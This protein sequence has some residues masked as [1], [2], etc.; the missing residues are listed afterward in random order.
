MIGQNTTQRKF[1]WKQWTVKSGGKQTSCQMSGQSRSTI[2]SHKIHISAQNM[3][4]FCPSQKHGRLFSTIHLLLF[5]P[6]QCKRRGESRPLHFQRHSR[7]TSCSFA[8]S[9]SSFDFSVSDSVLRWARV[10][11]SCTSCVAIS[12]IRGDLIYFLCAGS[13]RQR[14]GLKQ[15]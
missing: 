13:G 2:T 14:K 5:V 8:L 3:R 12:G 7:S 10:S 1:G 6:S 9:S 4:Y 15:S 11:F